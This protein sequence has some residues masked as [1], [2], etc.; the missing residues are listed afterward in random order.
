M[1]RILHFAGSASQV[2]AIAGG[3]PLATHATSPIR[4]VENVATAV[5]GMAVRLAPTPAQD[6]RLEAQR[7]LLV[8]S[9]A[10]DL[11][12]PL[13]ALG[14][15]LDAIATASATPANGSTK[16]AKKTSRSSVS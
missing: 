12:T 11:R 15:Y 5:T 2:D 13:F 6:A 10:H 4:E 9:I 16:R 7:R 1:P 14:G 8:T 3:D